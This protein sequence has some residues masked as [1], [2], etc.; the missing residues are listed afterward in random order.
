[1]LMTSLGVKDECAVR[2]RVKTKT[3]VSDVFQWNAKKTGQI[4]LDLL[5]HG[6]FCALVDIPEESSAPIYYIVPSAIVN[7]WLLDDFKEWL[8]TPGAQ[9]QQRSQ[10][11]TRR[12]FYVDER[13]RPAHGYKLKLHPYQNAWHLLEST[14]AKAQV[15][16]P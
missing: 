5:L 1:M 12:L 11:N 3:S 9:G 13:Q 7:G 15:A 4:F 6:D 8:N 16:S 10:E 2:I 14:S